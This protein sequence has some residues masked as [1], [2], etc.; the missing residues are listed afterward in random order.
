MIKE[1]GFVWF[2]PV[3]PFL[4][5]AYFSNK[6]GSNIVSADFVKMDILFL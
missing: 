1:Y 4:N 6:I 5:D 2:V 3:A